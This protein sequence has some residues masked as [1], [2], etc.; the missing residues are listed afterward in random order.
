MTKKHLQTGRARGPGKQVDRIVFSGDF[1]RP[2][3]A[4][5]RPTQHEN[6]NWLY[7][8]LNVPV[9]MA[10]G[11]PTE[12]VHWDNNWLNTAR[13][14][15]DTVAAIYHA[16]WQ[17]PGIHAWPHLFAADELPDFVEDMFLRFFGGSFVIGFELPPYLVNFLD[18][19]GIGFVDCSLSPVRFMNDLLFEVS[20]SSEDMTRAI[21]DHAVPEALIRL[22]A[23]VISSNVAK[24]FPRPPRPNSLLL[25]LQ[26]RFDKVVIKDGLFTTMNDCLDTIAD[27]AAGYDHVIIK[28]HPLE[29]Q[30]DTLGR[31]QKLLPDSSVSHENFYRLISHDN[32]KAVAALSSSCVLEAS[33][34]GKEGHYLLPGF[35]HESFSVGLEGVNIGDAVI[36]PDFWRDVLAGSDCPVTEKD[37]LRLPEKPN[38]FRQQLRSA[39]GFNQVDTDIP[40]AWA[41]QKPA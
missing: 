41:Q 23:G 27:L 35:T 5:L 22:Q 6:I 14:D 34:F 12:I 15:R 37:G 18:R 7:R 10:T 3:V 31:L 40:V 25:I 9:N 1:L 11:L 36:M 19:N 21:R 16:F 32:L 20:A 4:G 2:S 29:P 26:T 30:S 39:W 8:L 24:V 17:K 13:I 28:E 33:Y 38:R